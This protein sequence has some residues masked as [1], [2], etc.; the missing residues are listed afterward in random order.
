MFRVVQQGQQIEWIKQTLTEVKVIK[1][2][3]TAFLYKKWQN[4]C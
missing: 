1:P 3:K 4:R 2:P